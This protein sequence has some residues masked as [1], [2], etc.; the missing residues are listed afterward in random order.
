MAKPVLLPLAVEVLGSAKNRSLAALPRPASST[1]SLWRPRMLAQR[2]HHFPARSRQSCSGGGGWPLLQQWC[3]NSIATT[4]SAS[5]Q[6]LVPPS[7]NL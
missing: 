4:A 2:A 5:N 3:L 1:R 6:T 7:E